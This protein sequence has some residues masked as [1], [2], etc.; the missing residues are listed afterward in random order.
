MSNVEMM[1]RGAR[2]ANEESRR[3]A[4]SAAMGKAIGEL[5]AF[6]VAIHRLSDAVEDLRTRVRRLEEDRYGAEEP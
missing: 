1:R 3:L 5:S 6:V 2:E 4:E